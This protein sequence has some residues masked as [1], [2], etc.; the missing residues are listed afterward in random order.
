M[1]W[2]SVWR[3]SYDKKSNPNSPRS[4]ESKA[5]K[6]PLKVTADTSADRKLLKKL[7][8]DGLIEF[9]YINL[10]NAKINIAKK[11]RGWSD[12]NKPAFAVYNVSTYGGGDVYA[13]ASAL[14]IARE[15]KRILGGGKQN[16]E[17]RRQLLGHYY[18][19]N[20]IFVT[21]DRDD[22]FNNREALAQIGINVLF[23]N[24]L[25]SFVGSFNNNNKK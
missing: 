21:G 20:D 24:E 15:L 11:I 14:D 13:P 17:D 2:R 18:S 10:E 23:N 5:I 1:S 22:I 16:L 19:R 4:G 12:D 7:R 8:A 25:E 6:L 3:T 9:N